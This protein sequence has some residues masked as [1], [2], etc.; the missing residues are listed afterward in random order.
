MGTPGHERPGA[1]NPT[2]TLATTAALRFRVV[3][4]P[5]PGSRFDAK[6]LKVEPVK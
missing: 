1:H 3:V 2:T 6:R 5:E 4:R